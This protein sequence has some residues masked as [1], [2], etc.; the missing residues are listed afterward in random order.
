MKL[1]GLESVRPSVQAVDDL[2]PP[3]EMLGS[4]EGDFEKIGEEVLG[5]LLS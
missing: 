3:L 4:Y 2:F 1:F 5:I